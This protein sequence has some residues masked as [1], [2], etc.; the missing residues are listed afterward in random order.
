M[1]RAEINRKTAETDI[2]INIQNFFLA[3]KMEKKLVIQKY[4]ENILKPSRA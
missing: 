3:L 4:S 2:K 1:R